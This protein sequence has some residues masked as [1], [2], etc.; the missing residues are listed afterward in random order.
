MWKLRYLPFPFRQMLTMP[1]FFADGDGDGAGGSGAGEGQGNAGNSDGNKKPDD[2]QDIFNKGF[3]AADAKRLKEIEGYKKKVEEYEILQAEIDK[4]EEEEEQKKLKDKAEFDK[5]LANVKKTHSEEK[6]V[7]ENE[8]SKLSEQLK[9]KIIKTKLYEIVSEVDIIKEAIPDVINIV[10][11]AMNYTVETIDGVDVEKV[12]PANNGTPIMND[13]TGE[14][15][16]VKEYLERFLDQ[17]EFYKKS[18][19]D[20]G[21]GSKNLSGIGGAKIETSKQAIHEGLKKLRNK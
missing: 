19:S 16:S 3:K 20:G 9:S 11:N 14:P 17:K 8:K 5:A 10:Y 12:F 18:L 21:S 7:L 15:L 4:K 1:K 13:K 6:V 2:Y